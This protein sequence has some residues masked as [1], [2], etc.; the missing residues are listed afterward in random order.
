MSKQKMT[1][2]RARRLI[3]QDDDF[4]NLKRFDY[5]IKKLMLRYPDGCPDRVAAAA[6]MMT[7][8][9]LADLHAKVVE[10]LRRLMGVQT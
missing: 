5:S 2:D 1:P 9:Q 8:D 3:D 7:E 6:L 4:I 10:K